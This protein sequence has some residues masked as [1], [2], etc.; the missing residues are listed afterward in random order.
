MSV[1]RSSLFC[2]SGRPIAGLQNALNRFDCATLE[3]LAARCA[4]TDR[5]SG[6]RIYPNEI[7]RTRGCGTTDNPGKVVRYLFPEVKTRAQRIEE[8]ALLDRGAG[9]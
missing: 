5:Y 8:F 1:S 3:E 2:K 4:E 9:I 6:T 7:M